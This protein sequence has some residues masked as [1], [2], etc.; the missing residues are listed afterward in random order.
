M[1]RTLGGV[2]G[3]ALKRSDLP[4]S[5]ASSNDPA[6]PLSTSTLTSAISQRMFTSL[7]Y[8]QVVSPAP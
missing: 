4:A 1:Q 8:S 2:T 7:L 3:A 6:H 5:F